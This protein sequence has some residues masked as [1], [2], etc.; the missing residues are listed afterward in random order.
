MGNLIKDFWTYEYKKQHENKKQQ[1]FG[2]IEVILGEDLGQNRINKKYET[3]IDK[4]LEY[5]MENRVVSHMSI[6]SYSQWLKD[7]PNREENEQK[8]H[9][10]IVEFESRDANKYSDVV[11]EVAVYVNYLIKELNVLKED[12][13]IMVNNSKSLY[14]FVN[15][16]TFGLKPHKNLQKIYTEM[17][18]E[19]NEDLGLKYVDKSII[20]SSY[21][22][23]KTPNSWYK[24]GYFVRISLDELMFLMTGVLT[25]QNL[26]QSRKSFDI[27]VPGQLALGITR[28][29]QN[30]LKKLKPGKSKY[31]EEVDEAF[32]GRGG[33]CTKHFLQH[34]VEKGYR[35]NALVSVGIYLKNS[36]YSEDEVLENLKEIASA[37]NHDESARKVETIVKTIFRRNYKFS[38][39]YVRGVFSD[40]GIENICKK[41]PYANKKVV[42]K[43]I[44]VDQAVINSMWDKKASTRHY[45]LYITLLEKR[46]FNREINLEEHRINKRTLVELIK[47]SDAFNLVKNKETVTIE[48]TPSKKVYGLPE[49]FL[50]TIEGLGDTLKHYLRLLVKGYRSF[51]KYL[52]IKASNENL[53][54]YLGYANKTSLYKLI[55]KLEDMGLLKVNKKSTYCLYFESYKVIKIDEFNKECENTTVAKNENLAA[56]VGVQMIF[57]SAFEE[58]LSELDKARLIIARGSPG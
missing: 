50:G 44:F 33:N 30:A 29:Y 27:E 23:M 53:M 31:Q 22:V 49:A 5:T 52:L 3:H 24:G 12:I 36:G 34:I 14:V 8:Y 2:I 21:K 47:L 17:F 37:W 7:R 26:T 39:D 51:T 38:C 16:K 32:K 35:N 15:P 42:G 20:T 41:C 58:N 45:S 55:K 57:E 4:A 40:L 48:Y 18:N 28:L 1:Y 11:Q 13:V 9:P 54:E 19:I 56:A 43:D 10:F 46:L 6:Q 25:K